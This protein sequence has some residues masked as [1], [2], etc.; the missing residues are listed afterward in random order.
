MP[1]H[2]HTTHMPTG[3]AHL[4]MSRI[5][6]AWVMPHDSSPYG[7]LVPALRHSTPAR[8]PCPHRSPACCRAYAPCH[9]R[10]WRRCSR[11][12]QRRP[13]SN[14]RRNT[15]NSRVQKGTRTKA[16][17]AVAAGGGGGRR[18][19]RQLLEQDRVW[20]QVRVAVAAASPCWRCCL[21]LAAAFA[22]SCCCLLLLPRC[23]FTQAAARS[24]NR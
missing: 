4:M 20:L 9:R 13:P 14:S 17:A 24:C 21:L 2:R 22:S 6:G 1:A 23:R 10:R 15:C 5:T 3:S 7:N 8:C 12:P 16:A 11:W 18:A 19:R